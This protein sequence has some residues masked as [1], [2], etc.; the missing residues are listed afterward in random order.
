MTSD[1]DDQPAPPFLSP[2]SEARGQPDPPAE[3][4]R[5]ASSDGPAAG[6]DGPPPRDDVSGA[7]A[8]A[9]PAEDVLQ[10]ALP[11][12][13][14]GRPSLLQERRAAFGAA[15]ARPVGGGRGRAQP[16]TGEVLG[17]RPGY[18]RAQ[19]GASD[20][21]R[22]PYVLAGL[23]VLGAIVLAVAFVFVF[24]GGPSGA[25]FD[26]GGANNPPGGAL[27]PSAGRG[28]MARSII[29][30]S[31]R[32]GPSIEYSEVGL[33]RSGQDVEVAG[34]N[35]DASWFQ[36]FFPRN[37]QFR[38]WV[39]ASALRLPDGAL[40]SLQVA[41]AT[42][43]SRPTVVI[44]TAPPQPTATPA[45][46]HTATPTPAPATGPDLAVSVQNSV[47]QPGAPL[48]LTLRNATGAPI[49]NRNIRLTIAV[50]GTVVGS[51][52]TVVDLPAGATT[53]INTGVAIQAPRTA[54]IVELLGSPPDPNP[55]N[56]SAECVV[57][58]AATPTPPVPTATPVMP[59]PTPA[60][61]SP[62]PL[63]SPTPAQ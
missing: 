21:L 16:L 52:T 19:P 38:G 8:A 12:L 27:T 31:V 10:G 58:G 36:I 24:G 5:G 11:L 25:G 1:S 32:E 14:P 22:N 59:L 39:P 20:L 42:P 29:T 13:A 61:G 30:A 37:S 54:A 47:C 51:G 43:I 55:A 17:P 3:P 63:P 9:S 35:A 4:A 15:V 33:L 6:A 53:T 60:G 50:A 46:E 49:E 7:S 2:F 41:A 44:P 48:V 40:D 26:P 62:T 57:Q 34:R 45:P 23:A 28:I 56:N 18:A